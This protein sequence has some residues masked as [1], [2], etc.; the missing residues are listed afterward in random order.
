MKKLLAI[1]LAL[2]MALTLCACGTINDS[3]V[4]VFW[5]GENDLALVPNSLINAVDRAMY[6]ENIAYTHYAAKGDQAAQ[7]KQIEEALHHGCAGLLVEP[8]DTSAAQ[9]I[10]DHAKEHGV[11]VV[12]F[13]CT[14]EEAVVSSYDKCAVISTDE[15][16][17]AAT[18]GKMI[19][20]SIVENLKA[21]AENPGKTVA[22][23]RNGDGVISYC[24]VG[25]VTALVAEV[26]KVLVAAGQK[27][28][29]AVE[30]P[31]MDA[32][33]ADNNDDKGNMIELVITSSDE[34][35]LVVLGKLQSIGYNADRLKTHCI[36]LFTVG[37]DADASAFTDTSD[38]TAEEL[39]VLIYN[40]MN[41][42]DA[43][44]MAGTAMEDHDGIAVAAAE[45][46]RS[47][48]KGDPVEDTTLEIPYTIYT[49]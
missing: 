38:M 10:V 26:D 15:A 17:L 21:V 42:V 34:D 36:P 1:M 39:A 40:A 31:N 45:V 32:V 48:M 12:F 27:A 4:A 30:G 25:D 35:A 47:F 29:V 14:V 18:Y 37:A 24:P 2:V 11:S 7:L 43:G 3:D 33:L 19:G 20:E 9:Q 6:I 8:V 28:L 23:D 44:Q 41:V 16:T 22:L 5:S 49:K 13:N 46:L